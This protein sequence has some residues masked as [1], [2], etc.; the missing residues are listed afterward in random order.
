MPVVPGMEALRD[1][2]VGFEDRYLLIGGGACTLLFEGTPHEFRPP[3]DLD[4]ILAAV[5]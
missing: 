1:A 4:V 2:M 3:R 5:H